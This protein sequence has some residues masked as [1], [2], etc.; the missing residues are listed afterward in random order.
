[1]SISSLPLP[2]PTNSTQI[3]P[4][5]RHDGRQ[6]VVEY[7][8]E[9]DNGITEWCSIVFE[10][11]L[12]FE[13][14]SGSCCED[15]DVVGFATVRIQS[16]SHRLNKIL[17]RWQEAVG[18]QDW[19]LKQGGANRYRHFTIY[20]DDDGCVDVIAVSCSPQKMFAK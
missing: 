2:I 11:V 1:M 19:Q 18:W 9:H 6:L 16:S 13:F 10:D 14:R 12:Q 3:G 7:D 4:T 5:F 20:F 8:C 17:K 15:D